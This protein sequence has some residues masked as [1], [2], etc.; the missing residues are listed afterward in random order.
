MDYL[1]ADDFL[2]RPLPNHLFQRDNS[3][4]IYDG[5]SINPMAKPARTA[6][7]DQLPGRLQLPP[8]VRATPAPTFL[9]GNDSAVART[10]DHRGRRRHRHRQPRRDDRHG[11]AH[12]AARHRDPGSQPVRSRLRVDKVIAV[13]LPR[14]R[15]FMHLDT[16]HDDGRPRRLQRL[17]VPAR[18]AALVHPQPRTATGGDFTLEENDDLFAELSPRRSASTRSAC[19]GRRSTRWAPEREQW[20]DGNNFLAVAPGVILGY[21]RNTT[22]NRYLTDAG[23]ESSPSSAP[24][25]AAAAAVRGA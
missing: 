2:L 23:I 12:H 14:A 13:E 3:A 10:G 22:T 9:Y 15:A 20:D 17:P 7:D 4:W 8:D 1:R 11:R 6:G 16:A 19:C 24:S 18:R 25:S 5:L 21:E